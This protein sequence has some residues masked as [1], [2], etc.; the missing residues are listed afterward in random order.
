[1]KYRTATIRKAP[2][3][4]RPLMKIANELD[5]QLNRLTKQIRDQIELAILMREQ[6]SIIQLQK[7]QL[8][9][10]D[11]SKWAADKNKERFSD[12]PWEQGVDEGLEDMPSFNQRI[13]SGNKGCGCMALSDEEAK[14]SI[15]PHTAGCTRD[16]H[17]VISSH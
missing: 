12:L 9:N 14:N 13:S 17:E 8:R 7:T 11:I 16:S 2:E 3:T 15:V 5:K 1:M 4:V 6:E 10:S